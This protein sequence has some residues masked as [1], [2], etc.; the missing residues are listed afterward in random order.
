MIKEQLCRSAMLLG[1]QT[2]AQL[3][4][5]KVAIFGVGGVGSFCTEAL[6]RVGIGSLM[7]FDSDE[8]AVSN[9]NRQIMALHS[10]VGRPKVAVMCERI[11]DINPDASVETYQVFYTA[12]NADEFDLSGYDYIID[13]IDTVSSKLELIERAKRC[14][15]PIISSMGTGNKLDPSRFTIADIYSTSVCPLA[16]VMRYELRRKGIQELKVLYSTETA[17]KPKHLEATEQGRRQ[18]PG[19]VS[20]VPSVAGLMIAGEVIRDLADR[21]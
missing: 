17:L 8:I 10:T 20:F 6:A 15:V 11:L 12:E 16:K 9:I 7:L 2:I 3:A 4:K 18:T 14:N 13:A 19:S 5:K 21:K 1:E